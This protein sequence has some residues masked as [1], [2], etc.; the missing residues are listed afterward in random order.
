MYELQDMS[1]AFDREIQSLQL[2]VGDASRVC[3]LTSFL[4]IVYSNVFIH[5]G[6]SNF[7]C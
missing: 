6:N 1:K 4:R 7:I 2:S 3:L 5:L